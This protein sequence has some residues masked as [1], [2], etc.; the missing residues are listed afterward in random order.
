MVEALL[1]GKLSREQENMED[2]LTSITFGLLKYIPVNEGLLQLLSFAYDINDNKLPNSLHECT[3]AKYEF[4]PLIQD[5]HNSCEPDVLIEVSSIKDKYLILIEAKYN[6]EKTSLKEKNEFV[7]DQLAKEYMNLL[8][9][10]KKKNA[11][12]LL[13]YLTKDVFIP[14]NEIETS[15]SELKN[16]A[17]ID[18]IQLFWLSW[19][20]ITL[21]KSSNK[22][23][24]D[25]ISLFRERLNLFFFEGFRLDEINQKFGWNYI[26][27]FDWA[28][29][30]SEVIPYKFCRYE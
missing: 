23:I 24:L 30:F 29:N 28:I 14:K 6:S 22:M 4:W 18:N 26:Q 10:T 20:H 5:Y 8:S 16:K 13:I 19:R 11:Q 2:I 9:T 25:L 17:Q 7:G 12:P 27:N 1:K 3:N 15:I 21:I